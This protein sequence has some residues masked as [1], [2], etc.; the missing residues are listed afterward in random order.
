[1]QELFK[2]ARELMGESDAKE[3]SDLFDTLEKF[4]RRFDAVHKE[5][6]RLRPP[7]PP[8]TIAV[9]HGSSSI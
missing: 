5:V 9:G 8:A 3:P 1:M 6:T 7:P 4:I 2:E